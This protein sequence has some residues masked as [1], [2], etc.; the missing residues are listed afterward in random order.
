MPLLAWVMAASFLDWLYK[1]FISEVKMYLKEQELDFKVLLFA[2]NSAGHPEALCFCIPTMNSSFSPSTLPLF[3][4]L[5][6]K[7]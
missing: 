2:D 1:C 7:A 6:P 5:L 4:N 3:S